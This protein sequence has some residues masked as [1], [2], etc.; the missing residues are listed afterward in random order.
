[1]KK[2]K[3]NNLGIYKEQPRSK[4]DY[5]DSVKNLSSDAS[6]I[7]NEKEIKT[8]KSKQDRVDLINKL[9]LDNIE[10]NLIVNWQ[11]VTIKMIIGT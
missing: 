9:G 8:Q 4:E 11:V 2:F 5:T 1:M 10:K 6:E 3:L 7:F